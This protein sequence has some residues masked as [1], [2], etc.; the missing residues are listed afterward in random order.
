MQLAANRDSLTSGLAAQ[1]NRLP[2]PRSQMCNLA[3][4]HLAV[5]LGAQ[6]LKENCNSKNEDPK[7]SWLEPT[8]V[9]CDAVQTIAKETER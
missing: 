5:R 8:L 9:D 1:L 2:G 7:T 4:R 3:K 6:A